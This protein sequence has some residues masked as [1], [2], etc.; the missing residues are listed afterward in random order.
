MTAAA[1]MVA[2]A[3]VRELEARRGGDDQVAGVRVVQGGP[4]TFERVRVREQRLVAAGGEPAVRPDEAELLAGATGDGLV[5]LE[6]EHDF[7][8][9]FSIEAPGQLVGLR[10]TAR[11]AVH[12]RGAVRSGHGQLGR[13]SAGAEEREAVERGLESHTAVD[14][15][16]TVVGADE[17]RVA[18]EELV[19]AAG[20]IE[21]GG[22][23]A[24][25]ARERRLRAFGPLGVRGIVVVGQ[26]VDEEVEAVPGHEPAADARRVVVHGAARAGANRER[27]AGH[28]RREHVEVVE[29]ARAVHRAPH[30]GKRGRVL[31]PSPVTDH[32]H[33]RRHLPGVVE[34][35]EHGERVGG[36]VLGV[37]VEDCVADRLGRPGRPQS[38]EGRSV[39]DQPL[40]AL[41]VPDQVRDPVHV[42]VRARCQRREADRSQR[43]KGGD[44][45]SVGPVLG[46]DGQRRSRA[47]LDGALE[48]RG[49]QA[50][51]DDED[52]LLRRHYG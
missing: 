42:G 35:L 12:H 15:R 41:V 8:A 10:T 46:Q 7:G 32:V 48:H 23:G 49:R 34:R 47:P 26:V 21:Q 3:Q 44:G 25:G 19:G 29:A 45:A 31:R 16:L 51:D 40:L 27:R 37:Q 24:I 14:V 9:L 11:Q 6:V 22:D 38:A 4:R 52:E 2:A 33:G 20:G 5:A 28:V 39:L 30:A 18:L 17:D 36:E 13:A 50:V 43:G 1:R